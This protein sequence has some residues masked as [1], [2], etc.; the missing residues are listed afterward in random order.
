MFCFSDRLIPKAGNVHNLIDKQINTQ[1]YLNVVQRISASFFLP[2]FI[3]SGERIWE[4]GKRKEIKNNEISKIDFIFKKLDPN[5]IEL[6]Y[7]TRA[8]T[9][10][11]KVI[12]TERKK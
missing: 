3:K 4:S 5:D 7:S 6:I 1:L 12:N 2:Q 9:H 10:N 11:E 8:D